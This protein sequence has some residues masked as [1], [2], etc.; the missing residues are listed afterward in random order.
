MA[1]DLILSETLSELAVELTRAA[2][3]GAPVTREI[4]E[5]WRNQLVLM[6]EM[7][8]R[9]EAELREARPLLLAALERFAGRG[10]QL[11]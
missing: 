8:A 10:G 6:A 7:S 3:S 2:V 9:Q 4:I 1:D 5:A 11:Q